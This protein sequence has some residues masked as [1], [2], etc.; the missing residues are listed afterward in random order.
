MCR[1]RQKGKVIMKTTKPRRRGGARAANGVHIEIYQPQ[2]SDVCVAGSFNNWKPE[3]TPLVPLGNGRWAKELT[4]PEGRYEYRL[5]VDGTW[6]TDPN[7]QETAPNPYGSANSVLTI[8][9]SA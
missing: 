7:A 3:A 6:M 2:A 9:G 5:V 4:L 8:N 1:D